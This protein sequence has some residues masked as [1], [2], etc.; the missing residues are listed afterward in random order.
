MFKWR[1]VIT[2]G[3]WFGLWFD[4]TSLMVHQACPAQPHPHGCALVVLL[5]SAWEPWAESFLAILFETGCCQIEKGKN[6]QKDHRHLLVFSYK[7]SVEWKEV[8]LRALAHKQHLRKDCTVL[9]RS[10]DTLGAVCSADGLFCLLFFVP[11]SITW[12]N[13]FP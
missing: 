10:A 4:L 8:R 2:F 5:G 7:D 13:P 12:C 6:K 9:V 3:L 1:E 11:W